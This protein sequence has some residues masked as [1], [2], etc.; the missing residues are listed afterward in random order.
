MRMRQLFRPEAI[1]ARRQPGLGS[2]Q[3]VRPLLLSWLTVGALCAALLVGAFLAL[4]TYT[5]KATT[6]GVLV[7]DRGLIRLVP[8]AAGTVLERHAAEGQAVKAGDVLFVLALERPLLA[9]DNRSRV[10]AS[11]AERQRSLRDSARH[12]VA[13]LQSQQAAL[14]RRLQALAKELDQLD[15][16]ATLQQQRLALARQSLA[17]LESL[18]GEQFV[19]PAQVQAKSEELLGLQGAAQALTRQRAAL[20]RERAELEGERRS[21]PLAASGAAGG[22]EREQAVLSRESAELDAERHLV[23]RAPQDG[24]LSAVQ[25]EPGQAVSPASVLASLVPAGSK[26]QAHLY[27]PSSAIGFVQADQEVRLRLEAFPYQKFGHV[28]GRVLEVSRT[29]MARSDVPAVAGVD[30][31]QPLFRITVALDQAPQALPAPLVPGM[32]LAADVLLE[33]R[34]LVEWLIDPV[35]GWRNR[36]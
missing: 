1:E 34:R 2:V 23:V 3:L 26:L 16:E 19:S 13:L 33:R 12:Q 14:E 20:E 36:A 15:T 22:L 5:R 35:L 9:D 21:L 7:P 4:A 18:Q 31:G 28:S 17:R 8:T 11:L 32:R 24:T 25:A 6:Q 10:Q 30:A 29:P 27:A